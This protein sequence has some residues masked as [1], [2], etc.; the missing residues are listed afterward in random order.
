MTIGE[1]I[2]GVS[3]MKP[4]LSVDPAALE[5]EQVLGQNPRSLPVTF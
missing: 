4:Q 2:R 3:A 5:W 1:V